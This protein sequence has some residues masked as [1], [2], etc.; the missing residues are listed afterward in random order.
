[1]LRRAIKLAGDDQLSPASHLMLALRLI[2]WVEQELNMTATTRWTSAD[3]ELMPD[4]GKRY[5]IIDGELY[6]S[7]QPH[8]YHQYFCLNIASRLHAWDDRAGLGVT[9]FAPGVIFADDD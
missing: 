9:N 3:L 6:M 1:M 5:E 2:E 8:W 7:K 4:D